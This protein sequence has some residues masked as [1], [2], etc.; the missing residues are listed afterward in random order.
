[1]SK[2]NQLDNRPLIQAKVMNALGSVSRDFRLFG[3]ADSLFRGALS[4]QEGEGVARNDPDYIESYNG[5]GRNY[6]SQWDFKQ[7]EAI[8]REAVALDPAFTDSYN[9]LGAALM[10]QGRLEEAV[11]QYKKA[12]E[13]DPANYKATN[14]L[15]IAYVNQKNGR[16]AQR[17]FERA[18]ELEPSY[19]IY[20]N[21]AS[22]YYYLDGRFADAARMYEEALKINDK[23]FVIWGNL[24]AAYHWVPGKEQE[25]KEN[26]LL[27]I[28]KAEKKLHEV[29]ETDTEVISQ[30]ATY[31]TMIG[32]PHDGIANILEAI[33]IEPENNKVLMR[34][35]YIYEQIGRREEAVMW[36]SEAVAHGYPVV[37]I[38]S[39]PGFKGIRDDLRYG[40]LLAGNI[41]KE[42]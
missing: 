23:D 25:A 15:A 32:R 19:A 18:L 9:N 16:E 20:T 40:A 7:A 35:A 41:K 6:Y 26:Y 29:D 22:L 38:E 39:E 2:L 37:N 14:N 12:L 4:L 21:L 3:L 34:A 13:F 24:A 11:E 36:L 31:Y 27:A 42:N 8:F 1:V 30:L 28:E 5:I 33:S 10:N 17:W